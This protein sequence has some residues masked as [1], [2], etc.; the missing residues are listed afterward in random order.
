M[1]LDCGDLK[2]RFGAMLCERR[3]DCGR[4]YVMLAH[5]SQTIWW[6]RQKHG[7]LTEY[8]YLY[9]TLLLYMYSHMYDK[10]IYNI[11]WWCRRKPTTQTRWKSAMSTPVDNSTFG[12]CIFIYS[13]VVCA[14]VWLP[15]PHIWCGLVQKS[16]CIHCQCINEIN[17]HARHGFA[18]SELFLVCVCLLGMV[19]HAHNIPLC[20][21]PYSEVPNT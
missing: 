20:W 5:R 2:W 1:L 15:A 21:S 18:G 3:V 9:C 14:V 17:G 16:L 19:Y 4:C 8:N 10:Y 13:S 6:S 11:W 12:L 7:E